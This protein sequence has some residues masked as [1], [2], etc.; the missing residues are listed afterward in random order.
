MALIS[1]NYIENIDNYNN[2]FEDSI[3][4]IV[5]KY[6]TIINEYLKHTLDNVF[7]QNPVYFTYVIKRG[8]STLNHIFKIL[9]LYTK[10][11]ELIYYNCQKSYVYYI[12]FIG[13][14]GD[15]NHSFLELTS[16]DAT[17]F[18]YKK[19]IFD[20]INDIRKNY[21]SDPLSDKLIT[22]ANL[23]IEIYN[24]LLYKLIDNNKLIDV[25]KYINTDLQS[26]MQKIIQLFIES[27]ND[28]ISH[29][30]NVILIFINHF[31]KD[32]ILDYLDL[33][34]KKIK[35]KNQI[36]I[37]KLQQYLLTDTLDDISPIKYINNLITIIVI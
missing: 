3:T 18:V 4:V 34:I 30:L 12:E 20:I 27:N 32:N 17:L 25:I 21:V 35:K 8:I 2:M 15:N 5:I 33:F 14:I 11:L 10:N 24:T 28:D 7:I 1:K 22:N 37:T 16:K 6:M 13:Q 23:F 36:N 29:K 26:I 31:K 19:T 9:L